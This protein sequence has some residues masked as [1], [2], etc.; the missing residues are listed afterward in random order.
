[1]KECNHVRKN[2][3]T[4]HHTPDRWRFAVVSVCVL[5]GDVVKQ[6]TSDFK[7][8]YVMNLSEYKGKLK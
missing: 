2:M 4:T 1:M 3:K 8:N 7:I 5:C 6:S